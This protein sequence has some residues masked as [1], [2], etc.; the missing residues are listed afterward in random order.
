MVISKSTPVKQRS[1]GGFEQDDGFL[2]STYYN[3][4]HALWCHAVK[5]HKLTLLC[6]NTNN[7]KLLQLLYRCSVFIKIAF[8]PIPLLLQYSSGPLLP[9]LL[10][11]PS[12][13]ASRSTT[14]LKLYSNFHLQYLSFNYYSIIFFYCE[15]AAAAP[16][17]PGG[18]GEK[19]AARLLLLAAEEEAL[20]LPL[21]A[22]PL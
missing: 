2:T 14:V 15:P 4:V 21:H 19:Q 3:T 18:G 8:P 5:I 1:R 22:S 20:S 6:I 12:L 7:C 9:L 17:P 11:P 13:F 16:P 10:L